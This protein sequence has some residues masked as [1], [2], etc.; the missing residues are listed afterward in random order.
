MSLQRIL[1]IICIT[2]GPCFACAALAQNTLKVDAKLLASIPA[3]ALDGI[4]VNDQCNVF[5][6]PVPVGKKWRVVSNCPESKN[7]PLVDQVY[8]DSLCLSPTGGRLAYIASVAGK[9]FVVFNGKQGP[10][11][12]DILH[13]SLD[14]R[15]HG[16]YV[17]YFAKRGSTWRMVLHGW[18]AHYP[19]EERPALDVEQLHDTIYTPDHTNIACRVR[20]AGKWGVA[21]NSI[22]ERWY[23]DVRDLCFGPGKAPSLNRD[24]FANDNTDGLVV[25]NGKCLVYTA[26]QGNKWC[27]S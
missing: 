3:A 21:Y 13:D 22:V 18:N 17:S 27:L 1:A 19:N 12:D 2:F 11:Y 14:I 4:V 16:P 10:S 6:C 23:D 7:E 15:I 5:A 25:P 20:N 9:P 24:F 8:P 26:R